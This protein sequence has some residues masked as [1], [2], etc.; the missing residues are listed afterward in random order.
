V[1]RW[2]GAAAAVSLAL[3]LAPSAAPAQAATAPPPERILV[4]VSQLYSPYETPIPATIPATVRPDATQ[5][6]AYRG[7]LPD[8]SLNP[9]GTVRVGTRVLSFTYSPPDAGCDDPTG[10]GSLY[11]DNIQQGLTLTSMSTGKSYVV[12]SGYFDTRAVWSPD[13]SKIAYASY[14]DHHWVVAVLDAAA[15]PLGVVAGDAQSV[16]PGFQWTANSLALVIPQ[17]GEFDVYD[18]HGAVRQKIAVPQSFGQ[19]ALSPDGTRIAYLGTP[20]DAAAYVGDL[21]VLDRRTLRV[22][23]LTHVDPSFVRGTFCGVERVSAMLQRGVSW[24]P[25]SRY[26]AFTSNIG[27]RKDLGQLEDVMVADTTTGA[28]R[29]AWANPPMVCKLGSGGTYLSYGRDVALMGW[30]R[31]P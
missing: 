13:G 16:L 26:L 9:A 30:V 2:W 20:R 22:S 15:H 18:L 12:T 19:W 4:R 27:H 21:Y 23:Q 11:D 17:Q 5:L 6:R 10:C 28:V 31:E 8:Q 3:T 7:P 14:R 29:A 24:S 1:R 25:D